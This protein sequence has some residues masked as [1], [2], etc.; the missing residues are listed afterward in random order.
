MCRRK[1]KGRASDDTNAGGHCEEAYGG[2]VSPFKKAALGM[3]IPIAVAGIAWLTVNHYFHPELQ[4]IL[5]HRRHGNFVDAGTVRLRIPSAYIADIGANRLGA[6]VTAEPGLFVIR[7]FPQEKMRLGR[8][9]FWFQNPKELLKPVWGQRIRELMGG[10]FTAKHF[11]HVADRSYSLAGKDG[12]CS[13]YS[14]TYHGEVYYGTRFNIVC[15]FGEDGYAEFEGTPPSA[16]DFYQVIES[17]QMSQ[18]KN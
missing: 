5:W 10:V 2:D 1:R 12:I 3:G 16:H 14:I 8:M 4:A 6:T 7:S 13:E 17:A 15:T 9:E 18:E 11:H